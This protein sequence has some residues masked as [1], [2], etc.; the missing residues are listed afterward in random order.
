MSEE[1]LLFEG[2]KDLRN[3]AFKSNTYIERIERDAKAVIENSSSVKLKQAITEEVNKA[4]KASEFVATRARNGQ[5]ITTVSKVHESVDKSEKLV[6]FIKTILDKINAFKKHKG[7]QTKESERVTTIAKNVVSKKR[8]GYGN[9]PTNSNIPTTITKT[10]TT[11]TRPS[12][13]VF[14]KVKT[15]EEYSSDEDMPLAQLVTK[16]KVEKSEKDIQRNLDRLERQG[17][18]IKYKELSK[19]KFNPTVSASKR[20][21]E[22]DKLNKKGGGCSYRSYY[23]RKQGGEIA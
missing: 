4:K 5:E 15:Q 12:G 11:I 8:P 10:T 3:L 14:K 13:R 21:A 17:T 2:K 18:F 1:R 9:R 20:R 7:A 19:D 22:L 23:K 6:S 16:I